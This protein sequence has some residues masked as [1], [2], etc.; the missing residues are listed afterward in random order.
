MSTLAQMTFQYRGNCLTSWSHKY[1]SDQRACGHGGE[2]REAML[3]GVSPVTASH[4]VQ[5]VS[6]IDSDVSQETKLESTGS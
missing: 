2:V 3:A 6:G 4:S 5:A 1:C